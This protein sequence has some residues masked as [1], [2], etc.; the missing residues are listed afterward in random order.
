MGADLYLKLRHDDKG[1]FRDSY[2]DWNLLWKF[3]LS[4]WADV[5]PMLDANRELTQAKTAELLQMLQAREPLFRANL[6][7]LS[8][9]NR[10]Y[11]ERQYRKFKTFLQ[12]AITDNAEIEC[13]L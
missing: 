2:N 13:S 11:F 5:I 10:R 9:K 8:D 1:Y 6:S 12:T 7:G 3:G 4:W